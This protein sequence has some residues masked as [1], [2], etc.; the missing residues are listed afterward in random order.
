MPSP[1][2]PF[3]RRFQATC[4]LFR[5]GRFSFLFFFK[6]KKCW[7]SVPVSQ[8]KDQPPFT[9][10]SIR[11]QPK[12][13]SPSFAFFGPLSCSTKHGTWLKLPGNQ[14]AEPLSEILQIPAWFVPFYPWII[15]VHEKTPNPTVS[16]LAP[17]IAPISFP[18][19]LPHAF[20]HDT[21]GT[22]KKRIEEAFHTSFETH[23]FGAQSR[24]DAPRAR[25]LARCTRSFN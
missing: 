8:P 9:P 22:L 17:P 18:P 10:A 3:G 12:F 7:I 19:Q 23:V 21:V 15:V 25:N 24:Q 1:Q 4:A 6:E 20:D 11:R 2:D 14:S 13:P 16:R 5:H